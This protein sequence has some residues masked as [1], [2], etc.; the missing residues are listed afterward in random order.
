MVLSENEV[1]KYHVELES[2]NLG[3]GFVNFFPYSIST[4]LYNLKALEAFYVM[5]NF[6]MPN[7]LI[8]VVVEY[9]S[10]CNLHQIDI[11]W[12]QLKAGKKL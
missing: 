11:L 7:I 4:S 2:W 10:A 5:G 8:I 1:E 9:T 3:I 6:M 12:I